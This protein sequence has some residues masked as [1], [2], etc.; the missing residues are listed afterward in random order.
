MRRCPRAGYG[1][2][3]KTLLLI[4]ISCACLACVTRESTVPEV[5]E[6]PII[7]QPPKDPVTSLD[8]QARVL[9][10]VRSLLE[11]GSPT[12]LNESLNKLTT[13]DAGKSEL[14]REYGYIA[15]VLLDNIYPYA[16]G[17]VKGMAPSP[18]SP[19]AAVVS[20]VIQ[21]E[22]VPG[23]EKEE[24]LLKVVIGCLLLFTGSGPEA[25]LSGKTLLERALA[26][27]P[28]SVLLVYMK[29]FV[30]EKGADFETARRWYEKALNSD[31]NCYPAD[32]GLARLDIREGDYESGYDRLTPFLERIPPIPAITGL[33]A[34]A[35]YGMGAYEEALSTV[36]RALESTQDGKTI[37]LRAKI[38]IALGS[39]GQA[40][41]LLQIVEKQY[42][43][44]AEVILARIKLEENTRGF[45]AGLAYAETKASVMK[46]NPAFTEAYAG[47]LM[48]NNQE[49]KART[50]LYEVLSKDPG[51]VSVLLLLL[52]DALRQKKF[53]QADL[54]ADLI[55]AIEGDKADSN[56]LALAIQAAF[57]TGNAEKAFS[58]SG[59]LYASHPRDLKTA[60]PYIQSLIAVKQLEKAGAIIDELIPLVQAG[61]DK[62]KLLFLKSRTV[63]NREIAIQVL[64]QALF[65]DLTNT[66]ALAAISDAYIAAGELR[67]AVRYLRQAA[68]LNPENAELSAKLL[69]IEARLSQ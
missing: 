60:L 12:S 53:E 21:G 14:G 38:L 42:P 34:E 36:N 24:N 62:S 58:L 28:D 39:Y 19:Y 1:N 16:G 63:A 3:G 45:K 54:Y 59:E 66:E 31:K 48:Q 46:G 52:K 15:G 30:A 13:S 40:E 41:K 35:L 23:L 68:A 22:I 32:L 61:P 65:E 26:M 5:G 7:T 56:F 64:Q 44:D 9:K 37:F 69:N 25:F 17:K 18:S 43:E 49:E 33:A 8:S 27:R 20:S 11:I 55:R 2:W 10:E 50:L 29:G 47:L 57:G 51:R 4:L 67:T 6:T